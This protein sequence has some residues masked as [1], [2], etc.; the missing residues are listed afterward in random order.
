MS[1]LEPKKRSFFERLTGSIRMEEEE[2][3]IRPIT[4]SRVSS[5]ARMHQETQ[6][7]QRQAAER[8]IYQP[9]AEYEEPTE[10]TFEEEAEMIID[11]EPE[12]A[13]LAL[14]I[15]ETHDALI[16]KTMTAGVKKDDLVITLTRENLTIKGR[17]DN[18]TRHTTHQ[19]HQQELYWGPF[20]RTIDLPEEVD[21]DGAV[22]TEHH[23]LIPIK[24]PKFNKKRQATLK[25]Q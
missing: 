23:G 7:A 19:Y 8:R 3:D 12:E 22:A 24:L 4:S 17:R 15:Y 10:V 5:L 21:I 25:V 11:E 14:D 13:Q 1:L 6:E 16:V 18:D 20:S 2:E 9:Y